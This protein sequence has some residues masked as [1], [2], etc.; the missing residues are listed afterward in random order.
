MQ[1]CLLQHCKV[2][3]LH[4]SGEVDTLNYAVSIHCCKKLMEICDRHLKLW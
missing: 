2:V 3:C 1:F 4:A